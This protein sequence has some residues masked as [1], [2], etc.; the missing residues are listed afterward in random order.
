MADKAKNRKQANGNWN[1][2]RTWFNGGAQQQ[3]ASL[4]YYRGFL[5][6]IRRY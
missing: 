2:V 3:W 5:T 6:R 1:Y 4:S